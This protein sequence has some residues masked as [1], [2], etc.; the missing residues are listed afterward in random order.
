MNKP[1]FPFITIV[2]G[3]PEH[4]KSHR[5]LQ[6]LEFYVRDDPKA[7]RKGRPVIIFDTNDEYRQYKEIRYDVSDPQD[8][9][10]YFAYHIHPEIRRV[11]PFAKGK[12]MNFAQKEKTMRDILTYF[13]CG[14][15]LLDDIN[16]YIANFNDLEVISFLCNSRHRGIDLIIQFQSLSKVAT[17]MWQNCKI[18][19]FHYQTD[20]I[21]RYEE[22]IP[23]FELMKIA[24]T[25]VNQVYFG[26]SNNAKY[27]FVYVDIRNAKIIGPSKELF[28]SGCLEYVKK[29]M[30]REVREEMNAHKM[31][32]NEAI[33]KIVAEKTKQFVMK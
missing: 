33:K 5:T 1:V 2:T 15:V 14:L 21:S 23:N 27:F 8:N 19:R 22:R 17:T 30:A 11:R 10:K 26:R 6:E 13:R 20:D 9:G 16:T 28:I 24:Q 32:K 4:G 31:S 3:A 7:G 18:I 29:N 25:I 12:P